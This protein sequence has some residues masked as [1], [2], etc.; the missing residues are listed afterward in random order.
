MPR[1]KLQGA[2][3][4]AVYSGVSTATINATTAITTAARCRLVFVVDWRSCAKEEMT[5][6]TAV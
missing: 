5:E 4:V 2:D 6:T 3:E 1:A